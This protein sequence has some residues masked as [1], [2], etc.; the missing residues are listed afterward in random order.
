MCIIFF[1]CGTGSL[2][3]KKHPQSTI[4][5]KKN[6]FGIT[7]KKLKIIVIEHNIATKYFKKQ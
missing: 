6:L 4:K 7:S 3:L 5:K 1:V 2:K